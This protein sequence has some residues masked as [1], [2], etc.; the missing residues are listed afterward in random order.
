[1]FSDHRIRF[2]GA[3]VTMDYDVGG[4]KKEKF[5]LS[6]FWSPEIQN[7]GVSNVSFFWG[8][9]GRKYPPPLS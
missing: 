4:L 3:V 2:S 8:F 7:Q 1:M 5:I 6:Q 9:K